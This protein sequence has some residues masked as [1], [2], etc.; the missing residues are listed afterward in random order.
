MTVPCDYNLKGCYFF[1]FY[2]NYAIIMPACYA[3]YIPIFSDYLLI[4]EEQVVKHPDSLNG[5]HDPTQWPYF[6]AK[7]AVPKRISPNLCG[8]SIT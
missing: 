3:I 1:E 4:D 7:K 8:D 6:P 2:K 5:E